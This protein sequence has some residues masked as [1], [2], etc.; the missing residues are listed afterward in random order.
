MQCS[1]LPNSLLADSAPRNDSMVRTSNQAPVGPRSYLRSHVSRIQETESSNASLHNERGK[2]YKDKTQRK[3]SS[4]CPTQSESPPLLKRSR[5]EYNKSL[6]RKASER[7][8]PAQPPPL[9]ICRMQTAGPPT[10][11]PRS[12]LAVQQTLQPDPC[13]YFQ[14][15]DTCRCTSPNHKSTAI[16]PQP[17]YNSSAH[18]S[19]P[20]GTG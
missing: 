5:T 11:L 20:S 2:Q 16:G 18:R 13:T 17:P 4:M 14:R 1:R 6:P 8:Q 7:L 12:A 10:Q 19:S 9:E 15:D 3:N